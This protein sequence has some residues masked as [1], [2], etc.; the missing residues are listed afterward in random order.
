V[1]RYAISKHPTDLIR[2]WRVHLL[3]LDN[4]TITLIAM[5]QQWSTCCSWLQRRV[6]GAVLHGPA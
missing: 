6:D 1:I 3:D 2:P 5:R 4:G